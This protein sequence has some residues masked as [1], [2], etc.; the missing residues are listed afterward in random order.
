MLCWHFSRRELSGSTG[1][2]KGLRKS[3][4]TGEVWR[5]GAADPEELLK[6]MGVNI[7]RRYQDTPQ[8]NSTNGFQK[9]EK[10]IFSC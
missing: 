10:N 9:C 5:D 2:G 1:T 4:N 3:R 7:L 6:D 8:E